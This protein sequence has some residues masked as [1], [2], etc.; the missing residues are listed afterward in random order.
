MF[1]LS[2]ETE[3]I[4]R[5]QAIERVATASADWRSFAMRALR[6]ACVANWE[7]TSDDVWHVLAD[8]GIPSPGEPRAM[9]PVMVDAVKKGWVSPTDRVR[10]SADPATRNHARPQR[11][12]RSH[13]V[14]EAPS[15]WAF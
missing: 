3:Q 10:S 1:Q 7:I 15:E 5:D 12:Y 8:R 9:G 2:F 4:A 11:V 6:D 14:G 13:I